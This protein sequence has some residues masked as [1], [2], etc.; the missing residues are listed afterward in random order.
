MNIHITGNTTIW[1]IQKIFRK[2]FPYLKIE[3]SDQPHR[4]A[5]PTTEGHWYDPCFRILEIAHKNHEGYI[6]I[7]PWNT[8]GETEQFFAEQFGL[9]PQVFRMENG[10]WI[11]SAG[12]DFLSLDE[13]NEIGRLHF[14][15]KPGN[16]RIEREC[17]L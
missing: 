12:T 2:S 11:Q 14:E 10:R 9:Y 6:Q 16:S 13:Q 15:E 1:E 17:F 8:T 4:F 3:F 7:K 5:E